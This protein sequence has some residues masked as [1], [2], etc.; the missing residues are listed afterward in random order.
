MTNK[1]STLK[2]K[3]NRMVKKLYSYSSSIWVQVFMST[4]LAC[5][6]KGRRVPAWSPSVHSRVYLPKEVW[7]TKWV[8]GE[9][10]KYFWSICS[11]DNQSGIRGKG[12]NY[13]PR[14]RRRKVPLEIY[15]NMAHRLSCRMSPK[16][17]RQTLPERRKHVCIKFKLS[18]S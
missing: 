3:P 6:Y 5:R 18:S 8:K 7:N 9:V 16:D 1:V 14:K 4:Q 13:W 17:N 10:F 11:R 15:S 2:C 12:D